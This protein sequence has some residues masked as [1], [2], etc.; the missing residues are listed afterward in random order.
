[1]ADPEVIAN[2]QHLMDKLTVA[3]ERGA[4]WDDIHQTLNERVQAARKAGATDADIRHVLGFSSPEELIA[5]TRGEARNILA[6]PSRQAGWEPS[7]TA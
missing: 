7:S 2:R 3:R 1:M 6:R 4:S 5:A